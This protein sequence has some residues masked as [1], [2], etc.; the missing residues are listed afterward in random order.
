MLILMLIQFIWPIL[1]LVFMICVY[2]C[3]LHYILL[4]WNNAQE[5][6]NRLQRLHQIPCSNCL[7]FT[8]EYNLKCP[9]HPCKALSEEAIDC[10]DYQIFKKDL[11]NDAKI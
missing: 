10:V 4:A 1:K 11:A 5:N 7:F 3:F 8:G 6:W 9:V 2:L